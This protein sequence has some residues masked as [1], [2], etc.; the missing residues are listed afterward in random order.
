MM[1]WS[2]A[3]ML[4]VVFWIA[5]ALAVAVLYESN[6][7]WD[8]YVHWS[9][10]RWRRHEITPSMR[11]GISLLF[12]SAVALVAYG[13]VKATI[14]IWRFLIGPSRAACLLPVVLMLMSA[15][16]R[17]ELPVVP[18]KELGLNGEN[19]ARIDALVERAIAAQEMPG[20]VVAI[21]RT[22]GIAFLKAYGQRQVE[23]TPEPMTVDT[24][25]DLASL[26]KPIATATS[27]MILVECGEVRLRSAVA[28]VIPEFAASGKERI[29]IEQLL[30][31]H[32]GLIPDNPLS[33]YEDGPALAW[34]RIFALKPEREPGTAF[35]YS[36]VNFLVL[37]EVIRRVSGQDLAEFAAENIFRP[38]G[39]NE[40]AFNPSTKLVARAAPAE[41]RDGQWLR[42]EV[43]DPRS[44]LLGGVAGHAGLFSTASDLAIYCDALLRGSRPGAESARVMSRAAIAEMIRPRDL[45]GPRRGL[46][47]DIQ[48][49]YSSNRGELFSV[50]AF[51]HGGFTG[52]TLW[53]D[54]ELDLFVIFL[55]NRLHPDG[56]GSVNDL[57]GRIGTIAA[58][59]I[60]GGE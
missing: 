19:L 44:A 51:G 31:H 39:M 46:G 11:W 52:T 10:G 57:A 7:R 21:G 26:T 50:A 13:L 58:A 48:S 8:V 33:D 34:E 28:D 16:A 24:V 38:L 6:H 15:A 60:A 49:G 18:P 29:T 41:Q 55:S 37:G 59:A 12:G 47:W 25:F 32:S 42:G 14:H 45:G 20:C 2:L 3:T 9:H 23:P 40:T 4:I 5:L 53:I 17:A 36:D 54:P 56:T 43:H 1:K 30:T 27:V 22:G 35:V